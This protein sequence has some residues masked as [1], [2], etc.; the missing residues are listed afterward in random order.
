MARPEKP[1]MGNWALPFMNNTIG[2]SV[3]VLWINSLASM[4]LFLD[5]NFQINNTDKITPPDPELPT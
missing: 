3:T 4:V 5:F 2:F 1:H